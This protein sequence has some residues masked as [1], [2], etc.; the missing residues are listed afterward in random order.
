VDVTYTTVCPVTSV[1]TAPGKTYTTV[2]TTTSTCYTQVPTVIY[3]TV[4]GPDVTKTEQDVAY[5]TV[6]SL[7]PGTENSSES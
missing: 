5:T 4:K 1:V 3:E 6:T 7:C 2:Y